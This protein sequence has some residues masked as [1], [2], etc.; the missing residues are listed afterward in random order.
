MV[1]QTCQAPV[2]PQLGDSID[3]A[4]LW[5]LG[6]AVG[7]GM[8]WMCSQDPHV[9]PTPSPTSARSMMRTAMVISVQHLEQIS[10]ELGGRVRGVRSSNPLPL[11]PQTPPF[12]PEPPWKPAARADIII[13]RHVNVKD[14]LLLLRLEGSQVHRVVLVGL[15]KGQGGLSVARDPRRPPVAA[16][17]DSPGG[18]RRPRCRS[19]RG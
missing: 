8:V 10:A 2:C 13:I 14:Q 17:R 6:M 15:Q 11:H 16:A 4:S 9:T 5:G 19:C 3:L 12:S 1:P 7:P 18:N